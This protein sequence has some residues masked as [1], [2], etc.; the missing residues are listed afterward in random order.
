[1]FLLFSC[2]CALYP[3]FPPFFSNPIPIFSFASLLLSSPLC[4][5]SPQ[6]IALNLLTLRAHGDAPL[7]IHSSLLLPFA[8]ADPLIC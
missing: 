2:F 5:A 1:M 7:R 8:L 6:G 4:A 3:K